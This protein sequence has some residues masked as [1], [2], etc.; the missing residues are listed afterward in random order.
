[1][2]NAEPVTL[3]LIGCGI[4]VFLLLLMAIKPQ[5]GCFGF[6]G[7]VAIGLLFTT[8]NGSMLIMGLII[9]GVVFL[10]LKFG[11]GIN[12]N[13]EGDNNNVTINSRG[14]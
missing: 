4:L 10:F 6:L 7:L 5:F 11:N 8:K 2:T 14:E 13:V 12:V 3:I 9:T 1:M